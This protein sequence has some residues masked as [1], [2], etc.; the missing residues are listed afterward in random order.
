M[1]DER[2]DIVCSKSYRQFVK[3]VEVNKPRY[4]FLGSHETSLFYFR[5]G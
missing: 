4:G 5:Q 2:Q 1:P 3:V